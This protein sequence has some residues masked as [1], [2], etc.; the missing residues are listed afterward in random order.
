MN[1]QILVVILL[2]T[3]VILQL[4]A[5]LIAISQ[6]PHSGKYI[7]AWGM[8]GFALILM[9][10]RRIYPI[11][12]FLR[13]QKKHIESLEMAILALI[14]SLFM[15]IGFLGIRLLFT[16]LN[17]KNQELERL[18]REDFLT[19]IYNRRYLLELAELEVARVNRNYQHLSL[20]IIDIDY[21][22]KIND[23]YGHLTGDFVL[24]EMTNICRKAIRKTDI[25]GRYGGEEFVIILPETSLKNAILV[26]NNLRNKIQDFTIKDEFYKIN[27]NLTISIGVSEWKI[28]EL[29]IN[30]T[31]ERAD[32]ALYEAKKNGRNQVCFLS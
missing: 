22:K 3:A 6:I 14:I 23:N 32:F 10:Q 25:L 24:K 7:F 20:L 11:Y 4:L 15:F 13:G 17:Y 21:F 9:I 8:I 12:E 2:V 31:I 27:I 16:D 29:S 19:G 30:Q 26:A 18:S 5:A 1:H 28:N